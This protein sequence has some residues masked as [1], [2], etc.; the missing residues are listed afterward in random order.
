MLTRCFEK[1]CLSTQYYKTRLQA[2]KSVNTTRIQQGRPTRHAEHQL[3]LLAIVRVRCSRGRFVRAVVCRLF[4]CLCV[5]VC[6]CLVRVSS[7]HHHHR[8]GEI[9]Q[10]S[11]PSIPDDGRLRS[12]LGGRTC[13]CSCDSRR[14]ARSN[15]TTS[16]IPTHDH[17]GMSCTRPPSTD[18]VHCT[19][20][21]SMGLPPDNV[22]IQT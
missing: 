12:T 9:N 20:A 19:L 7:H 5:C 1:T 6:V 4:R 18:M 17:E 3:L 15:P 14:R 22:S 8:R 21:K 13:I 10:H 11:R 16:A 2:C